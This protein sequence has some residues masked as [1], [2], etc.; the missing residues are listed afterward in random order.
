MVNRVK[1]YLSWKDVR[2]AEKDDGVDVAEMDLEQ[3][4]DD[5]D[6]DDGSENKTKVKQKRFKVPWD[7]TMFY[8]NVIEDLEEEE[9]DEEQVETFKDQMQR[10]KVCSPSILP[11]DKY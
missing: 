3:M 2:K 1:L 6:H 4:M 9:E 7:I 8:G 5:V 10:L 11:H